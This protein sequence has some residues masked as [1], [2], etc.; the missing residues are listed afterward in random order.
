MKINTWQRCNLRCQIGDAA[1]FKFREGAWDPISGR[2][3]EVRKIYLS[4]S[5]DG[6]VMVLGTVVFRHKNGQSLTQDFVGNF[7]FGEDGAH[8]QRY[9]A[10]LV[11]RLTRLVES[12]RADL[13][14]CTGFETI[15]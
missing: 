3:H 7:V 4:A 10:W 14:D 9:E 15:S 8:F 6:D 5:S 11:R 2:R 1:I 12:L 13:S